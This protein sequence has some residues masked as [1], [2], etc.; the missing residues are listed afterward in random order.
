M[1]KRWWKFQTKPFIIVVKLWVKRIVADHWRCKFHYFSFM[2]SVTY[3]HIANRSR[4]FLCF[5]FKRLWSTSTILVV[6]YWNRLIFGLWIK[7]A[8]KKLKVFSYTPTD[9]KMPSHKSNMG[10]IAV[11]ANALRNCAFLNLWSKQFIVGRS[12][13]WDIWLKRSTNW[14]ILTTLPDTIY[15]G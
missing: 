8:I 1:T 14:S 7:L 12:R 9:R 13:T 4:E 2:K 3:L 11:R 15:S 10:P 5:L 6:K